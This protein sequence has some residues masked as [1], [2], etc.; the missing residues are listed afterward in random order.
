MSKSIQIE[1]GTTRQETLLI[2][3]WRSP[4]CF[5]AFA[6]IHSWTSSHWL[7][8]SHTDPVHYSGRQHVLRRNDVSSLNG[9]IL[10]F[11][12]LALCPLVRVAVCRIKKLLNG[13]VDKPLYILK[14]SSKSA[15]FLLS[16]F[17]FSDAGEFRDFFADKVTGCIRKYKQPPLMRRHVACMLI[18]LGHTVRILMS[19][20]EGRP[21]DMISALRDARKREVHG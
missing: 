7:S 11:T 19:R 5:V 12:S 2:S 6:V 1:T 3:P 14:T 13:A 8:Q 21:D 16:F 9:I 20:E 15:L 17:R 18:N 10:F 4:S